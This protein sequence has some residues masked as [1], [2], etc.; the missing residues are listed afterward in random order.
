MDD[1]TLDHLEKLDPA[2]ATTAETETVETV[3]HY[4]PVFDATV[5]TAV[6]VVCLI[7]SIVSVGF[8]IFHDSQIGAFIGTAAGMLASGFGVAYNPNR[9]E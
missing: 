9:T 4:K 5:R 2:N 7:A 6:Y 1:E 8:I 3:E